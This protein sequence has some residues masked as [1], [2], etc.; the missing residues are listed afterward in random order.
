MKECRISEGMIAPS[1]T[2]FNKDE[3]IDFKATRFHIN[4]MVEN[5]VHAI[6]ANGTTQE[7]AACS[8]EERMQLAKEIIEEVDGRVPVYIG[9]STCATR[10]SIKEAQW[11]E[12]VGAEAVFAGG[13]YYM[14]VTVE[15]LMQFHRDIAASVNIPYLL[16]CNPGLS[17]LGLTVPQVAQLTNEGV[18]S[19]I[20]DTAGNPVRTQDLKDMCKPGT[21][22]YFGDD[23]GA[24]QALCVG[25]DGWTSGLANFLPKEA[26]EVWDLVAVKKDYKA[27]WEAW[28]KILPVLN[29]TISK[30]F[31]GCVSS[32]SDWLQIYKEAAYIRNGT[33]PVV[34]RPLSPLPDKDREILKERM[35]A[36]GYK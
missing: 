10:E 21:K 14:R 6:F 24:Y 30:D 26:L 9:V 1:I 19:M 5:G 34:R 2:I 33:S 35:A 18:V 29:M 8:Q 20:K 36:L 25:A 28:Q 15:E 16:Y 23:Y 22:V 32:R 12:A 3:S 13:P 4:W 17:K 31:Y 11:A 7:N 27:G